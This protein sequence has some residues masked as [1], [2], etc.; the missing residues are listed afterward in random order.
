MPRRPR[1]RSPVPLPWSDI[2]PPPCEVEDGNTGRRVDPL[3][4][5]IAQLSSY[6]T[7]TKDEKK[8]RS[9]LLTKVRE[10]I[11]G[12][13][14][15]QKSDVEPFG[16]WGTG[17]ECYFSDLDLVIYPRGRKQTGDKVTN[18]TIS[19]SMIELQDDNEYPRGGG[20]DD[21]EPFVADDSESDVVVEEEEEELSTKLALEQQYNDLENMKAE[22]A[23]VLVLLED[24]P[25]DEELFTHSQ[26]LEELIALEEGTLEPAATKARPPSDVPPSGAPPAA[27]QKNTT[28][29][30]GSPI[31]IDDS[32][33]DSDPDGSLPPAAFV[34]DRSGADTLVAPAAIKPANSTSTSSTFLPSHTP[35]PVSLPAP[36]T[37]QICLHLTSTPSPPP[38]LSLDKEQRTQQNKL[39]RQILRRLKPQP[40][41]AGIAR[42]R[43]PQEAGVEVPLFW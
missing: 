38:P 33:T 12:I 30:R 5:S 43:V 24:S 2:N 8:L 6:I 15:L 37:S 27:E 36:P 26:T 9:D 35:A 28:P 20:T 23:D 42:L 32:D 17:R 1:S 4:L 7:P 10:L 14:G 39:L 25:D 41:P 16:S 31:E 11:R 3:S 21:D 18:T 29:D 22:L 13:P 19:E 40:L 34:L